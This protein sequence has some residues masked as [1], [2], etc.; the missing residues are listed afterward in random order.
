MRIFYLQLKF[1]NQQKH[2][3]V[4][5]LLLLL[6]WVGLGLAIRLFNLELKPPASIEIA[7]LGYSL[8]HGFKQ[9]PLDQVVDL[10]TLLAPLRLDTA[11]GYSEVLRRLME[12]STHPA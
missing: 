2:S 8:G 3:T 12:E 10:D 11:I 7:T 1:S 4:I 6:I 5:S 9:I